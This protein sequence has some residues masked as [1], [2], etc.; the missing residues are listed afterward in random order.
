[1][2]NASLLQLDMPVELR[3]KR[4]VA[5]YGTLSTTELAQAIERLEDNFGAGNVREAKALLAADDGEA[6]ASLLLQRYYDLRYRH[7]REKFK[8]QKAV[9]LAC[10]TANPAENAQQLIELANRHSL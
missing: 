2:N 3:A 8:S 4:L 6:L 10:R 1:M 7:S 9:I 5:D